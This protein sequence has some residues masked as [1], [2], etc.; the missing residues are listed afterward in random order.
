[1]RTALWNKWQ[2]ANPSFEM[3][4]LTYSACKISEAFILQGKESATE[5]IPS[6]E[7]G[8]AAIAR[9]KGEKVS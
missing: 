5:K 9:D 3:S 1:M 2:E 6:R 7:L 8:V 4:R